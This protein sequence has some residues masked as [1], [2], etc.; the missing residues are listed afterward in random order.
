MTDFKDT[1]VGKALN[2]VASLGESA[3]HSAMNALEPLIKAVEDEIK[4]H[5]P[6]LIKAA[7]LAAV[8]AAAVAKTAGKSNSDAGQEALKAAE[9]AALNAGKVLGQDAL[10][11]IATAAVAS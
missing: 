5:G 6:E 10:H 4:A 11:A 9:A 7:T 1:A 8:E 2:Y 3:L